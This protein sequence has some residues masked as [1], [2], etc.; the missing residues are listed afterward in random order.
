MNAPIGLVVRRSKNVV[1]HPLLAIM[2]SGTN[3]VLSWP[4]AA[5]SFNL[6]STTNLSNPIWLPVP[7]TLVTNNGMIVVTNAINGPMRYF[8]LSDP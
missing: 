1:L 6:Q 5:A 8:R 3:S 4:L 2:K 7:G